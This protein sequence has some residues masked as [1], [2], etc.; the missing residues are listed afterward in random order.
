[1][2]VGDTHVEDGIAGKHSLAN[3]ETDVVGC[4]ARK[5]KNT[6]RQGSQFETLVV[7]EV[8]VEGVLKRRLV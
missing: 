4:V 1:M 8:D 2:K 3:D 6:A 5:M 7:G